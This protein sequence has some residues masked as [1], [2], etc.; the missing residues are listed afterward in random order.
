M[1]A[2]SAGRTEIVRH[3]LK[4]GADAKAANSTKQTSLHYAASKGHIDVSYLD[5]YFL[6]SLNH[7]LRVW[8]Q[9]S[10]GFDFELMKGY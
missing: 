7:G 1:I 3:L 10:F 9:S 6:F 8:L 5:Y 4:C 2:A